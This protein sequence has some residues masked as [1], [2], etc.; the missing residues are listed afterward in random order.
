MTKFE[1]I[2][3]NLNY[4]ALVALIVGQCVVKVD[5][6]IGN[7]IYLGANILSFSRCF[8]LARPIADKVKDGCCLGIT[9]GLV[10]MTILEIYGIHIMR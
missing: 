1:K 9:L 5:F 7:L 4:V 2:W 3:T 8:V 10:I 6:L